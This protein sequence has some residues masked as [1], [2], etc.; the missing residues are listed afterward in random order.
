LG[1]RQSDGIRRREIYTEGNDFMTTENT[2]TPLKADCP[3]APCSALEFLAQE[4]DMPAEHIREAARAMR[5]ERIATA[6]DEL[7][8][9]V[10]TML[11]D[12]RDGDFK[13]PSLAVI[14][15]EGIEIKAVEL[16]KLLFRMQNSQAQPPKVD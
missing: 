11:R 4:L 2:D 15:M 6:A 13:L 12:W 7:H 16:G 14:H 9:A 1:E 5:Y 8:G 10:F 3:S